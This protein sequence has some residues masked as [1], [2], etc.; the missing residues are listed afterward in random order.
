[1]LSIMQIDGL[2]K[3]YGLLP[4][5]VLRKADTFDL[6]VIDAAL[7]YENYQHKKAMNKGQVPA[8][9]YS[10]DQL[11]EMFNKGKENGSNPIAN[12]KK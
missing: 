5:E 7:T 12:R 10:T 9:A 2:G 8:E 11:L 1:M 4:S 3:R 6:Y